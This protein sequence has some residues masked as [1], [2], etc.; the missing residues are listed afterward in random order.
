[1]I[2]ERRLARG[3]F[4]ILKMDTLEIIITTIKGD[5]HS[6]NNHIIKSDSYPRHN[7]NN[8]NKFSSLFS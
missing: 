1:M 6:N 7:N 2:V 3:M 4:L 5:S 8:D